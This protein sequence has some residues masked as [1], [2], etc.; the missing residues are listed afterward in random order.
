MQGVDAH[1]EDVATLV[2]QLDDLLLLAVDLGL[3]QSLIDA[4]PEVD[5]DH[6]VARLEVI[7]LLEGDGLALLIAVAQHHTLL[8]LQELMVGIDGRFVGLVAEALVQLV[9]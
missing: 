7:D 5:V 1:I 4:D 9:A 6:I 2:G 8:L 3:L